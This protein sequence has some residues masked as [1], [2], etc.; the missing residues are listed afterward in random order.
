[1]AKDELSSVATKAFRQLIKES[2]T[3]NNRGES[4]V[5]G[6]INKPEK[7][8]AGYF[9]KNQSMQDFPGVRL[10]ESSPFQRNRMEAG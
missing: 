10:S 9:Q 6:I 1:M 5:Q 7:E 2:R 4:S 8:V 3:G